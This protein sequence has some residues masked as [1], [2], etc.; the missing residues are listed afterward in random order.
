[1]LLLARIL[2]ALSAAGMENLSVRP[3]FRSS[4]GI[5][6]GKDMSQ[7]DT[8]LK[9]S[10]D[11]DSRTKSDRLSVG[12]RRRRNWISALKNHAVG[13][14]VENCGRRRVTAATG[15]SVGLLMVVLSSISPVVID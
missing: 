1:M 4:K 3:F 13:S 14:V 2:A 12:M 7:V 10:S 11:K 8:W 15:C 5:P 9:T 6:A